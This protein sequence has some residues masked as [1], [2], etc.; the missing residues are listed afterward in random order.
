MTTTANRRSAPPCDHPPDT[1]PF[2]PLGMRLH[3]PFTFTSS[4]KPLPPAPI[5]F[6]GAP[7]T[8][9]H[10][11]PAEAGCFFHQYHSDILSVA[12]PAMVIIRDL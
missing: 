1:T 11:K 5:T 12:I 3:R 2:P 7:I 9:A 4:V 8:C 6:A 10:K